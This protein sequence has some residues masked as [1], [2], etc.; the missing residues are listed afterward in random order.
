LFKHYI[1]KEYWDGLPIVP[2]LLLA[3]LVIGCNYNFNVWFKVTDK[4]YFGTFINVGGAILTIT[5]NYI[6]IPLGGYFASTLVTLIVFFAM[7]ATCYLLGQK[8]YPIPY[9][10]GQELLLIAIT[11]GLVYSVSYVKIPSQ[12]IATS[13]HFLVII[14]FTGIVYLIE[15]KGL[16]AIG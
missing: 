7:A 2:I 3:Y 14:A 16:R 4:T 10:I 6:F 8:Y 12:I 9:K 11:M 15:R 13:F 5:L 1:S